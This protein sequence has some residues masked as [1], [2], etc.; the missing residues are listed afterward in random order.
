MARAGD[1]DGLSERRILSKFLRDHIEKVM[2]LVR[3]GA[4]HHL[5]N[6]NEAEQLDSLLLERLAHFV[7]KLSVQD[8]HSL[9][10]KTPHY[11]EVARKGPPDH[12]VPG[13]RPMLENL[14]DTADLG[15][16]Q[17]ESR[18]CIQER[19]EFLHQVW[20]PEEILHSV[21]F[22]MFLTECFLSACFSYNIRGQ[23]FI[24]LPVFL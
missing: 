2:Q 17:T 19:Q 22:V 1:L 18:G 23:I 10:V 20:D 7:C 24:A 14:E 5:E 6:G 11:L 21:L 3:L 13:K 15:L 8:P 16:S 12:L 9:V 4:I